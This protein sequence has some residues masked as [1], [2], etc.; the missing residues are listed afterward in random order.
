MVYV[1]DKNG[2]PL[3]P[4]NRYGKVRRMLRDGKA[5][6]VKR[7]PFTIRLQYETGN[8]TQDLILGV[9]A[10]Y[11]YIGVSVTSETKEVYASE[12]ELR[13]DIV[14][15]LSSRREFRR[16]R[17]NHKIRYRKPRFDNRVG[18]KPKGWL[19]PSVRTRIDNHLKVI[20][21]VHKILPISR[22]IIEVASFDIQ[23]IKNPDI[24]GKGYQEGEQFGF[25]NVREY[26]LWRDNHTCQCCKGKSGDNVLNVHHLESRKTGGN[27]PNDLI[28]VC[29]TCHDGIHK[30]EVSLPE[31]IKRGKKFNDATFMGIMRW[32]VYN[33][34]KETYLDVSLTY[35]YITKN[36]RITN[37]LDKSHI[38]DAR[39]ITG[40][41]N[42]EPCDEIFYMKKVRNHNRQLHKATI[43]KGGYR[44]ANQAPKELFGYQLYDKIMYNGKECFVWG[45]RKS[46]SFLIRTLDNSYRKEVTYKKLRKL[47]TRKTYLIE[48][49]S[50]TPP[51]TYAVA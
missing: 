35:G 9:D 23:K 8:V 18:S 37:G 30:G 49:R 41:P 2:Y 19:A 26:V 27:A 10:G 36:T 48:R 24:E 29:E 43:G 28:T 40:C 21:D 39:C 38:V 22:I 3:M 31:N 47:E 1:L 32:E 12:V 14:N 13:T 34:L 11:K 7:C 51:T 25:W 15:N 16:A 33:K 45:R 20:E 17:R 6:C 4:T 50:N 44:K 46:G 42:V 5:K